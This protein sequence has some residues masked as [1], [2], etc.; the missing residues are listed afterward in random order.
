MRFEGFEVFL[1]SV[2]VSSILKKEM[3][4]VDQEEFVKKQLM[5]AYINKASAI[6]NILEDT[7]SSTI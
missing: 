3:V 4:S 1:C 5:L 2:E 7:S 6:T